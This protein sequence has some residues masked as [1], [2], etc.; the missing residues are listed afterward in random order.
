MSE[1]RA[2]HR[3]DDTRPP[4]VELREDDARLTLLVR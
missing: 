4:L 3:P 2:K 1:E